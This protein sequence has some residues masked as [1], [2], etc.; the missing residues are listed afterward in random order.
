MI[1]QVIQ[2]I[3][4]TSCPKSTRIN[5]NA[6]HIRKLLNQLTCIHLKGSALRIGADDH[7]D[8]RF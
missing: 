8:E 4:Q 1:F 3:R 2:V 7:L 6:W 5:L